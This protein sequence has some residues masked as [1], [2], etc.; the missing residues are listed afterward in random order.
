MGCKIAGTLRPFHGDL[1]VVRYRTL[2]RKAIQRL[3]LIAG[4][5]VWTLVV[6]F[7]A[8]APFGTLTSR[9]AFTAVTIAGTWATALVT[10]FT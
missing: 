6:T 2:R 1:T 3:L 5:T 7:T 4:C 9:C 10:G 8:F